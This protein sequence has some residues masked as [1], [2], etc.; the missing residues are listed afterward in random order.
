MIFEP[1]YSTRPFGVGLGLPL[2]R[3]IAEQHGGDVVYGAPDG[4]GGSTFTLHLPL[5]ASEPEAGE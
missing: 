3:S 2:V 5:A 1:L 4:P